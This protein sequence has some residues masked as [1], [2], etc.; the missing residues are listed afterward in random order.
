MRQL[1][2]VVLF[3]LTG[4][5]RK[6]EV[7]GVAVTYNPEHRTAIITTPAGDTMTCEM[8]G[9]T[10]EGDDIVI[11]KDGICHDTGKKHGR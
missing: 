7:V 10:A 2:L 9:E 5:T 4:C 3:I 1:L 8:D 6:S 11:G